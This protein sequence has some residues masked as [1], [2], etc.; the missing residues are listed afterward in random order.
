MAK[1]ST[2]KTTG[3]GKTASKRT[4]AAP[5]AASKKRAVAK[6]ASRPARAMDAIAL[7]RADHKTV[8]EL[9]EARRPR[10]PAGNAA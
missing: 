3:P 1:A 2:K 4:Q 7:L 5:V 10:N 9:F 6:K 8:T